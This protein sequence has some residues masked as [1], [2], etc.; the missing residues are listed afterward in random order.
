MA[1]RENVLSNPNLVTEKDYVEMLE[2][3]GKGWVCFSGAALAGFAMVDL[4]KRNIWALFVHPGFEN[5][6]IGRRLQQW[7]LDWSF[8]QKDIENLWLTTAPGTRAEQFY[9]KSGW[10][11]TGITSTGEIRFEMSRENWL[12]RLFIK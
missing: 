10:K 7:M 11:K 8:A 5:Q 2:N 12:D 4:S 3:G 9:Q 6:G 1:V